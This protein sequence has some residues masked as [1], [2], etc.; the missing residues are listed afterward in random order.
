MTKKSNIFS[1]DGFHPQRQGS[2][3]SIQTYLDENIKFN[4]T[5]GDSG[6]FN[7]KVHEPRI[8][9]KHCLGEDPWVNGSAAI[10][11]GRDRPSHCISGW[12]GLGAQKAAAIDL[13]VGRASAGRQGKG[14]FP[15]SVVANNFGADAARIYI[16]QLTNI[17][18]N[19]GL[20]R[21]RQDKGKPLAASFAR[22]GI[23]IK[24]DHVRVIGREGIKIVTGK[25][26]F[27][28]FGRKGETNSRGG[29]IPVA[30]KIELIAG[31]NT[32]PAKHTKYV[33]A[34]ESTL[35]FDYLPSGK[36]KTE[37][38]TVQTL[39]PIPMGYNLV[40]A[41]EELVD[42]IDA[43]AGALNNFAAIQTIHN[44][45]IGIDPIRP[46]V[47]SATGTTCP[48]L[49]D[50]VIN[51]AWQTRTNIKLWRFNYIGPLPYKN[52]CSTNCSVT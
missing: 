20:A 51:S 36:M 27:K 26:Q 11:L 49:I 31:N 43:I 19:F 3:K 4:F 45:I 8:Y 17:D 39:Q 46:W 25:A 44:T 21:G 16:S 38:E 12:G 5:P 10:V 32:E 24:A 9:P 33:D 40:D 41:L 42:M 22:S 52:I 30:G 14:P 23:G 7:T 34:D 15:G 47:P 37:I 18:L 35:Q 13:V 2:I 1:G 50:K 6:L 29:E 28:G 48:Q